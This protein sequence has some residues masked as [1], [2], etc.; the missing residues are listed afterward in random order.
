MA[1]LTRDEFNKATNMFDSMDRNHDGV[2]DIIEF[3][4]VMETVAARSGRAYT[5]DNV[6]R[7]F[8]EADANNDGFIDYDEWMCAR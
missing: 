8:L 4:A 7:M 1:S 2:V 6:R 3:Q 5:F